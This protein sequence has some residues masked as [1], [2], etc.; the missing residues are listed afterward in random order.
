MKRTAY[1]GAIV[2]SIITGL[3]FLFG[4]MGLEHAHPLDLLAFRFSSAFIAMMIPVLF[5]WVKLDIDK[6]MLKSIIPMAI[7]SPV[8]FFG[9]QSFGLDLLPSSEAGIFLAISPIFTMILASI[10]LKEKTTMIQKISI[11]VSVSGVIY[12]G[13]M[14]SSSLDFSSIK[15]IVLLL[16]SVISLAIYNVLARKLTKDYS[17]A[18]LTYV[19]I[20]ISFIAFNIL[21]LG[22]HIIRGDIENFISPLKEGSF[23][24]AVLYLGVL[25]TFITSYLSNFILSKIESYKMSVFTN[26]ATVISIVAGVVVL[27]EKI[28]YYHII[29]S[30]LIIAGVIGANFFG[31]REEE[32]QKS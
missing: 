3:S 16:I 30:I 20:G 11:L 10:V 19:M 25:S 1:V 13:V 26:L 9:L 15:G 27:S 12:I 6:E 8:I 29:G 18:Q 31:N 7:F 17:S 5:K 24:I 2:Y 22:R 4:K 23:I 28:Y 32:G 21:A 14:K